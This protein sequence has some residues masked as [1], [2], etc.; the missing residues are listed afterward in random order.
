VPM[1]TRNPAK[2]KPE[3]GGD[4]ELFGKNITGKVTSV[5]KPT[6]FVM[7][8]RAPTWPTGHYGTL[9]ASIAQQRDT[10]DLTL[11]LKGVPLGKEDETERN[12]NVFYINSL[13]QIG[14]GTLL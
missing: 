11:L 3:V 1:W 9:T 4:V 2:I 7:T 12:L 13:K 14:L 8:W 5:T 10:T 6:E